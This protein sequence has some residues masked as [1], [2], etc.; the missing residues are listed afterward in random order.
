MKSIYPALAMIGLAACSVTSQQPLSEVQNTQ[1]SGF[2]TDYSLLHPGKEGQARLVYID[3]DVNWSDYT[4]IFIEPVAFISEAD[5]HVDRND[6]QALSSY[7][8]NT[9]KTHLSQ[10]LPI[11]ERPGLHVLIVRAALTDVTSATPGLRSFSVVIPQARLIN[12]AQSVATGS[13]AFV[14]SARSEVEVKDG[15]TGRILAEAVD[16]RSGGMSIKNAGVWKWGDAENAMD[17]WAE[18]ATKRLAALRGA[19]VSPN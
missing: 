14:G 7:Y 11:V 2:L 13:Y 18:Q 12:A 15:A 10:E 9:L 16:G 19:A 1:S 17:Y 5:E 3:P 6:Q 4:A 8:Y